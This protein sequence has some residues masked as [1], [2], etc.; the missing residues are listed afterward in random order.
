MG[1]R[2][3]FIKEELP[4]Q[5]GGAKLILPKNYSVLIAVPEPKKVET[6][7][8]QSGETI[9]VQE[10]TTEEVLEFGCSA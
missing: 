5:Q 7:T 1:K 10:A 2:N 9:R 4:K 3:L 6:T 8:L